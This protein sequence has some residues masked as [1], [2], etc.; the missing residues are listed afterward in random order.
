M[1][2]SEF[3]FQR[4]V[5]VGQY[6]PTDSVIHRLDPRARL[7]GGLLLLGAI[8]AAPSLAGLGAA[9]AALILLILL[10]RVPLGHALKGLLPPL[11]F[12]LFLILL[13]ILFSGQGEA[14][15]VLLVLGPVHVTASDLLDGATILL[16]FAGLILTLTLLSATTST[17]QMVR[18]LDRLTRP[19]G[20]LG[21]PTQDFVLM[22]QVAL[23]FL[24]LLALEAE[25]IVKSQAS[26]GAEW[27]TGRH[28]LLRRVRQALPI[29]IPLFLVSLE[30][31]ENLALAM[32]ARGYQSQRQRTSMVAMD[33]T[34]ADAVALLI[35]AGVALL[36]V[37]L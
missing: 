4:F 26:R 17:T 35:A 33:F 6:M 13:Q 14:E 19:L 10:A 8:T 1:P 18:G 23:R 9:F 15:H 25:R 29:L 2:V 11:P 22:V 34:L 12:I 27:G 37:L 24:P 20:R 21:L 7:V 31:A 5:T 36:I 16:R 32:E 30:R 28:G 3:E